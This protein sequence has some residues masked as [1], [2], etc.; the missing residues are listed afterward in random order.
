MRGGRGCSAD[1]KRALVAEAR[2]ARREQEL[3]GNRRTLPR[4]RRGVEGDPGRRPQDRLRP[5]ERVLQGAAPVRRP[6]P[7]PLRG[8]RAAARG[9]GRGEDEAGRPRPRR[10]STSTEWAPT[11]QAVPRPDDR[12]EGRGPGVSRGRRRALEAV[13]VRAGRLLRPAVRG[14]RRARRRAEGQPR[15]EAGAARRGEDDSTR[16]PT[17][18]APASGCGRSTTTGRRSATSRATRRTSSRTSS[19]RSSARSAKPARRRRGRP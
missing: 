13:Q 17:R 6:A 18:T 4:D 10:S 19:A 3:E 2:E 1:Q 9:R 14:V 16:R 8:G 11:A 5:V 12:V 15:G 7:R